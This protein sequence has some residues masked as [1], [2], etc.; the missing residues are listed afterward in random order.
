MNVSYKF[1]LKPPAAPPQPEGGWIRS[2]E[3]DDGDMSFAI[4]QAQRTLAHFFEVFA[5]PKPS[6]DYFLVK[7]LFHSTDGAEHIWLAE[8]N[9]SVFPLTG[10]IANQ[11]GVVDL[12][13]M[14]KVSF[15]PSQITDWMYVED[16]YAVGAFTTQVIRR[17]L[18][19][20]ERLAHDAAF[21]Y[22]YG[23]EP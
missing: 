18:S 12:K 4:E 2:F 22:K 13:F 15:H 6:Q 5:N 14:Q 3:E 21:P 9:A 8:L 16:G 19:S 17:K 7:A 11:P 23:D 10:T 20:A 1:T